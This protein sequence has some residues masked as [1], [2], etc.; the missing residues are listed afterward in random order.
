[1]VDKKLMVKKLYEDACFY[2]V[3]HEGK[4]VFHDLD[5]E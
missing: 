3:F 5:S 4:R 2:H 1:M